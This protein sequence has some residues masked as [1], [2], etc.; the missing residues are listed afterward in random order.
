MPRPARSAA[1]TLT[2]VNPGEQVVLRWKATRTGIFVYHCA[3]G[4]PMIPWHVV[5]GMNGAVMVLPRDGLNDGKGN[6]LHYDK[7]VYI[8]EQDIYVPKDA[9]GKFKSYNSPREAY[10]DTIEVMRK[11]MPTHVVFNGKVGALDRQECADRQGRR[12]RADRALAGQSRQPS[13]S[14]RRPWRLCLGDRQVLQSRRK[15]VSRPGSF[16]AARQA[17]RST[18]S[19]SPASTPMS[20]TI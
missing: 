2:L 12:D 1:A 13:A 11:L 19:C 5:S 4:G 8:G 17:P 7:V 14:D 3:P 6:P 15:P 20:R 18:R 9:K 16:A 10:T